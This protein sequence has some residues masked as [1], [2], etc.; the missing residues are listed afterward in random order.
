METVRQCAREAYG[1]IGAKLAYGAATDQKAVQREVERIEATYMNLPAAELHLPPGR[2]WISDDEGN[3]GYVEIRIPQEGRWKGR[4]FVNY[5]EDGSNTTVPLFEK[6]VRDEL[7]LKLWRGDYGGFQVCMMKYGQLTGR[8]PV[9]FGLLHPNEVQT[10]IHFGDDRE[11]E[12]IDVMQ[13]KAE[14]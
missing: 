2:Y 12:C 14:K 1:P 4:Y 10:G 8:C 9:C 7:L 5:T 11:I 3:S 13:G 6:K